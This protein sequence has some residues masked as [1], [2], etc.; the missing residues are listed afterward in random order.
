MARWCVQPWQATCKKREQEEGSSLWRAEGVKWG[1]W[2]NHRVRPAGLL[3]PIYLWELLLLA[4]LWL[5]VTSWVASIGASPITILSVST[6]MLMFDQPAIILKWSHPLCLCQIVFLFKSPQPL[7]GRGQSLWQNCP[8]VRWHGC[9][10]LS[11]YVSIATG[12]EFGLKNQPVTFTNCVF[13]FCEKIYLAQ[14]WPH[15]TT[16]NMFSS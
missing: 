10:V 14:H 5:T 2:C 15:G 8:L 1:G 3:P 7:F 12:R 11:V 16:A 13:I 9:A 6:W 4:L